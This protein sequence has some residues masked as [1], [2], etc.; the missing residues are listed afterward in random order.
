MKLRNILIALTLIFGVFS[1][2]QFDL[3]KQDDPN[4]AGLDAASPDFYFNSIQLNFGGF[5]E[6]VSNQTMRAT[7]MV[8][9]SSG[10]VYE[11]A[12]SPTSFDGTWRAA[13]S[14]LFQDMNAM[15]PLAEEQ[16]L[17]IHS[18]AVKA[19]KAYI[20]MTLV[21]LFGDVPYTEALQGLPI[22]S[23]VAD[24]GSSVYEAALAL[25]DEALV[26]LNIAATASPSNDIFYDGDVDLWIKTV[27]TLKMKYYLQ[28][29][30]VNSSSGTEIAAIVAAG[31]FISSDDEDFQLNYGTER[32]DPG[33]R[34]PYYGEHYETGGGRYLSNFYMQQMREDKTNIDPRIR[35][36]FYRQ[37]TDYS[38]ENQFTLDCINY[39]D[40]VIIKRPTHYSTGDCFCLATNSLDPADA[41]GY[42]GRDH[43]NNDGTPPDKEKK[44]CFGVYPAGGLTD[45]NQGKKVKNKG[46]DGALGKG[47]G[48][49]M[50]SS[51]VSF[52]RAEAALTLSTGDDAKVMLENGI[53]GSIS[54]VFGFFNDASG[55]PSLTESQA[56]AWRLNPAGVTAYTNEVLA[57]YDAA[58]SD[59]ERLDVIMKEYHIAAWGNGLEPF[60][61][62]RR[63]GYPSGLQPTREADSGNFPRS[64]WYPSAYVNLNANAGQK[65][66]IAQ[67]VF[68]DTNPVGFIK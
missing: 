14:G 11:N 12:W 26:D 30:L 39:T 36:Y 60:N 19:M 25:L 13:Y 28:T 51:W 23:P 29:R 8:A 57:R 7:R 20:L 65:A 44:T 42:W 6:N 31:D 49:I 34:H 55:Q 3:E 21:D 45:T 68:W 64:M 2:E 63:T 59:E 24:S 35:F 47:I 41:A 9:M 37:D 53:R 50:L 54:K 32:S 52:M 43:G 40:G 15:L 5:V 22:P 33:S 27:N 67:Q 10:N 62:Y 18:G 61:G 58:T 4:A 56:S 48:P 38:D 66:S 46:T 1:C 17:T 16:G